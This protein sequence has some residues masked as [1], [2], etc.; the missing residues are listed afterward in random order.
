MSDITITKKSGDCTDKS[1]ITQN[2]PDNCNILF[3]WT[4]TY[5]FESC[6]VLTIRNYDSIDFELCSPAG[7]FPIPELRDVENIL[8]KA[9]GN[10]LVIS[11]AWVI[12]C[13]PTTIVTN[14]AAD[15]ITSVQEQLDFFLNTFQPNSIEDSYVISI[16]GITRFGA[17]R[18]MSFSKS[19]Q[20]PV[21]YSG[22][23]EFIAGNVVVG[24]S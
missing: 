17:V 13:E 8:V 21:T 22:R 23:L 12:T 19:A 5:L 2:F 4:Q 11:V 16:D 1:L 24:E 18:K 14:Q 15:C 20:T 6:D 7:D 3:T 9:E 10:R